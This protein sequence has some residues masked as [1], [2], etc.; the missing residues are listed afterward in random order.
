MYLAEGVA[1]ITEV[2]QKSKTVNSCHLNALESPR[3]SFS[4]TIGNQA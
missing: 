3:S 2:G 4:F 1:N